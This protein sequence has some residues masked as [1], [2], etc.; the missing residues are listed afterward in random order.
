L[1][2]ADLADLTPTLLPG[3]APFDA[4]LCLGNSLPHLLTDAALAEALA[5]FATV[6]RPGGL[7]IVQNRNFDRVWSRR[8]R[9]MGPQSYD[10]GEREWL[11]VR[12]YDFLKQTV[13]FNMVRL[14]RTAAAWTQDV[15]STELRPLFRDELAAALAAAALRWACSIMAALRSA[16][17]AW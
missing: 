8:E 5:D 2:R 4:V 15:E 6:L 17:T 10:D 1:A 7:L 14:Q 3:L 9:F 16:P 12:F 13:T 11:F